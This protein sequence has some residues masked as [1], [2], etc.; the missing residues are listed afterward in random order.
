MKI[1]TITQLQALKSIR[2]PTLPSSRRHKSSKDY[3]RSA[4]K[5]ALD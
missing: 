1:K 5:R 2:K 4:W 3:N